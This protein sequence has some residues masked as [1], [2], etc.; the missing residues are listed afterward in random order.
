[1]E[2]TSDIVIPI[3]MKDERTSKPKI[4]RQHKETHDVDELQRAKCVNESCIVYKVNC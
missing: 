1:M 3:S 2:P 4:P